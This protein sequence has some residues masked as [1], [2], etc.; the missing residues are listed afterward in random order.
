MI[1]TV[2][3]VALAVI[4][5]FGARALMELFFVEEEIVE[6]GIDIMHIIIFVV[7]LQIAQVIYMGC[8]RGAGDTLYTAIASTISVT[9]V[10]T[11]GSYF[12]GYVL[13]LGIAG[14]WVGVIA[15]QLS[16]FLF[17]SIRFRRGKW[18]EIRI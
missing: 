11:L 5:F 18:T 10:R 17:A 3:S 14:I 15:D 16:R 2:I 7:I 9:L 12:F 1:G 8:L 4:Y 6:I 13:N